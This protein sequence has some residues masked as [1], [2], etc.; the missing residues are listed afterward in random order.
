MLMGF[1]TLMNSNRGMRTAYRLIYSNFFYT[2]YI[3][4]ESVINAST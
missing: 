1:T 3:I 2:I 4:S